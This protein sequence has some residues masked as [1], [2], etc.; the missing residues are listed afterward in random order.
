MA[1]RPCVASGLVVLLAGCPGAPADDD[2]GSESGS[3]SG[4]E[5]AW[6][7]VFRD[8]PGAFFSVWG[9]SATDVWLAGS[10]PGDGMGPYAVHWDGAQ[11]T[12]IA[13]GATVDLW[14]VWTDG[15][16]VWLSGEAGTIVRHRVDTGTSEVMQAPTDLTLFGVYQVAEGDVWSVGGDNMGQAGV[17]LHY[18]GTAWTEVVPEGGVADGVSW[19][20]VWGPAADDVWMVG[21][22]GAA[23]HY[24]G[25]GWTR[26]DVPNGR[27]LF[28]VHGEGQDIV[29]VGGFGS[30]LVVELEGGALVDATPMAELV[31]QLNGVYV[32]DG[33]AVAGGLMGAVWSREVGGAW[34]AVADTPLLSSEDYHSVYVDPDGGIWAA[35]GSILTE[36]FSRGILS[37]AGAP[38][39]EGSF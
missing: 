31:P 21:L 34:A 39:G 35:G 10:D 30:G 5:A 38:V 2:G 37:H 7:V 36:P 4:G 16:T 13:T 9:T 27:P 32:R 12:R 22:G 8:L 3:E 14:W 28:T 23:V 15:T 29:A 19:F 6:E 24:D 11:W 25:A 17:I 20:K 1:F 18:D 26:V 33:R